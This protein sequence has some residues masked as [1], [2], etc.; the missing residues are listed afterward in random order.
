MEQL[1][2]MVNE[3]LLMSESGARVSRIFYTRNATFDE[4]K[5]YQALNYEQ[6]QAISFF[7]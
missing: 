3:N 6:Y 4:G 5:Q 7:K 2:T 1:I